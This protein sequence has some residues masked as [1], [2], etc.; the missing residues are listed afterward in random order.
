MPLFGRSDLRA[1]VNPSSSKF[2]R[3]ESDE[4][5][6]GG[7]KR[8]RMSKHGS[9]TLPGVFGTNDQIVGQHGWPTIA[10]VAAEKIQV[11]GTAGQIWR[12]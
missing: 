7:S 8:A 9:Y 10:H 12:N 1:S 4:T 3:S 2:P 6:G 11:R 5:T